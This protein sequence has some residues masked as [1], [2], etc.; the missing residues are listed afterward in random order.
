M[1]ATYQQRMYE[2]CGVDLQSQT[3]YELACQG[4]IRPEK[5]TQPVV[6]GIKHVAY[7]RHTFTIEVQTMNTSEK[8]LSAIIA[9]VALNLRTVAHC[10]Q[11]R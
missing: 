2:L 9:E 7:N 6:Y 10:T 8:F 11:I 1:Q 3:A 5:T 4:I